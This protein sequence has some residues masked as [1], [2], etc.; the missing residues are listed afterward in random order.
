V[1]FTVEKTCLSDVPALKRR[2]ED[3]EPSVA[4]TEA[5]DLGQAVELFIRRENAEL[6]ED[7]QWFPGDQAIASVKKGSRFYMLQFAPDEG[8]FDFEDVRRGLGGRS[9]LRT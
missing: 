4:T 5:H 9:M 1:R 6:V 3:L 2:R 8:E 7:V